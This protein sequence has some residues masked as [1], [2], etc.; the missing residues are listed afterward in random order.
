MPVPQDD[1]VCRFINPIHWSKREE[2][3]REGAF[4]P[5]EGEHLSVW[6]EGRLSATK[7]SIDD[8]KIEDL[9]G[10][11][12]VCHSTKTYLEVA[13]N[14]SKP[15]KEAPKPTPI[16]IQVEFRPEDADVDM[17][18]REWNYAHCQV[19]ATVGPMQLTRRF[20]RLMAAKSKK[21]ATSPDKCAE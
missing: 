6:H 11:G 19:E 10:H 12:H 21:H 3:P 16:E 17:P 4:R 14:S 9:S 18:W 8:L 7:V 1:M 2:G 5:P 20:H 13:E 15:S